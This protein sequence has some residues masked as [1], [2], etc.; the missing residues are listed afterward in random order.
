VINEYGEKYGA[1]PY[2]YPNTYTLQLNTNALENISVCQGHPG[3]FGWE[4]FVFE[5][6]EN[7]S[8]LYI[9]YWLYSYGG[10]S[11]P[12]ATWTYFSAPAGA[13]S[14]CVKNANYNSP[15][16][17]P[18]VPVSNLKQ[19]KLTG[20]ANSNGLDEIQLSTSGKIYAATGDNAVDIATQGGWTLSEFNVLG[21]GNGSTAYFNINPNSPAASLQ[22][23]LNVNNGTANPPTCSPSYPNIHTTETNNLVL[24]SGSCQPTG[25]TLP[26]ITFW[27]GGSGEL[28]DGL[29]TG[30]PHFLTF[31]ATHYNFQ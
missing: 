21:D 8:N 24:E 11:C 5:N 23:R 30:D 22:V 1:P 14:G 10:G 15:Q 13:S 4:Q 31:F 25:G 18:V 6:E 26:A 28:P 2:V 19:L 3:C 27:E 9:Q 7:S 12:D 29:S 20:I 17:L 16:T